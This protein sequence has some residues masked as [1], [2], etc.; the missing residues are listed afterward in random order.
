MAKPG[1]L[2]FGCRDERMRD[3]VELVVSRQ[4]ANGRWKL[5][6]TFNGRFLVD[7]EE[8]AKHSKWYT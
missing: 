3:A 5:A 7:M 2:R 4:D 6:N 1:W 8:K